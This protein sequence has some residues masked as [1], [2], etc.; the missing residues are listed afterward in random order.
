MLLK[1]SGMYVYILPVLTLRSPQGCAM[2]VSQCKLEY[3]SLPSS[4][5]IYGVRMALSRF[6]FE[7]SFQLSLANHH[8]TIAQYPSIALTRQ[9]IITSV[10]KHCASSLTVTWLATD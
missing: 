3:R 9:H 10:Y 2:C 8:S 4:C 5:G 1:H 6:C 7:F